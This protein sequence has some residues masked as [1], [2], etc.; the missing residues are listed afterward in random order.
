MLFALIFV[1]LDKFL[2]LGK[3]K[4]KDFILLFALIFVTLHALYCVIVPPC[5]VMMTLINRRITINNN[6]KI[7]N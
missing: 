4:I 6:K 2:A 7:T 5:E 3:S 1:T